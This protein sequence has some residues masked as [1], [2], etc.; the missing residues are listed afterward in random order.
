MYYSI[1]ANFGM[2]ISKTYLPLVVIDLRMGC[3][4]AAGETKFSL[5]I[6]T[7]IEFKNVLYQ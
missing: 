7:H 5:A 4:T 6:F 2:L 1:I 3:F